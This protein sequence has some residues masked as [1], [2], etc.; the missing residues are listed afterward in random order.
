[1]SPSTGEQIWVLSRIE[2]RGGASSV[3]DGTKTKMTTLRKMYKTRFTVH[4][5]DEYLNIPVTGPIQL[6]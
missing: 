6:Y 1:M 2:G 5:A 3:V 4:R